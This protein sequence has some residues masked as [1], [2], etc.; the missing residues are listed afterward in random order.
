[1]NKFS[2]VIPALILFLASCGKVYHLADVQGRTYRIEK[3]SYP[4]DVRVA[5]VIEPYKL[6]LD[7]TMNEVIGYCEKELVKGKPN[8]TLTNWFADALQDEAQEISAEP[9]DFAVQNYGGI[10]VPVFGKGPV[11]VGKMYELMPFDNV[12]YI[13][14]LKGTDVKMLFDKMAESGGWPVSRNVSFRIEYGK[15]ENIRIK[16]AALDTTAVYTAAIPDYIANG[17][18]NMIFLKNLPSV[19]TGV[20]LRDM[21]I[22][23]VKDLQA[24]GKSINPQEDQR[25]TE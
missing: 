4:V 20:L 24:K 7:K 17:G 18:D 5:S 8:S 3:A 12:M 15:A 25:I 14:K 6:E 21:L 22:K 13:L 16:G 10:R 1:M 23:N 11:T 19:N 2:F 9:I